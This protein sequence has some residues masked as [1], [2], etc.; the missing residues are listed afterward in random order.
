M[1]VQEML[2]KV[3]V[4]VISREEFADIQQ[5]LKRLREIEDE[6]IGRASKNA[7]A[8]K[9]VCVCTAGILVIVVISQIGAITG[10]W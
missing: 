10:W 7:N 2:D 4:V 1:S 6:L 5:K 3:G 8:E 9:A